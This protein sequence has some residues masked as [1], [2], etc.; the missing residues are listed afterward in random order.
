MH[1]VRLFGHSTS[2]GDFSKSSFTFMSKEQHLFV[3]EIFC[4]I[5]NAITVTFDQFNGSL[6]NKNIILF[7]KKILTPDL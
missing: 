4:N 2:A 5:I 6:L 3:I 7:L 1:F